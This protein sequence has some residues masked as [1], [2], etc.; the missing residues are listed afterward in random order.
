MQMFTST[1]SFQFRVS[2]FHYPPVVEID[3]SGESKH[4]GLEV[5]IM[6]TIA[7]AL[8]IEVKLDAP[9]DGEKWGSESANGTWTG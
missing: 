4:D 7:E 6:N 8:N 9:R 5:R 3:S 2:T 1:S